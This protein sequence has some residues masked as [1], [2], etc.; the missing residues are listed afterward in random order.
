MTATIVII[1]KIKI[2]PSNTFNTTKTLNFYNYSFIK[3]KYFAQLCALK[4][5]VCKVLTD[6]DW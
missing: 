4:L 6:A 3:N 5:Y 1:I 2:K